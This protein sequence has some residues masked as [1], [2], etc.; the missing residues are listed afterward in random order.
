MRFMDDV[1]VLAPSRWKLRKAV[2]VLNEV[3]AALRLE[4]HPDKTFI[5]RIEKGFTVLGYHF[6]PEGLTVAKKTVENFLARTLRL[7]EQRPG[8]PLDSSRLG[9]YVKPCLR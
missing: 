5:G 8:E 4:K 6:S 7:Y 9:F 3:F 2:K 1:V